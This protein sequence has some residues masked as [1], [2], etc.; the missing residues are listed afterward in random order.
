MST[1][2]PKKLEARISR[3]PETFLRMM[4]YHG[5]VVN[6]EFVTGDIHGN[7]G[8]S[9]GVNLEKALYN[10]LNDAEGRT[11]GKGWIDLIAQ[12]LSADRKAAAKH[13]VETLGWDAAEFQRDRKEPKRKCGDPVMPVPSDAPEIP[14]KIGDPLKRGSKMLLADIYAYFNSDGDLQNYVLRFED[15]A[16]DGGKPS[17]EIRPLSYFETV[18]GWRM[19]GPSKSALTTLFGLELL[20]QQPLSSVILVEGEKAALAARKL[21]PNYVCVT[22]LGGAG[23][24]SKVDWS[25]LSGRDVIYFPDN[26]D[27]GKKTVAPIQR[28]LGLVSAA[29]LRV[30][31]TPKTAPKGWD[32]ADPI[33]EGWDLAL[34]LA[35]A[36]PLDLSPFKQ[37]QE[38]SYLE[39]PENWHFVVETEEF[40]HLPTGLTVKRPA[41]DAL[42]RHLQEAQRGSIGNR[43]LEDFRDNKLVKRVYLPGVPDEIVVV[44]GSMRVLNTWRP[45]KVTAMEGDAA[46]FVNHLR[47]LAGNDEDFDH[48]ADMLAFMIQKQGKKLKSAIILVGKQ[49]TGKSYVG[50]VMR[51]LFGEHNCSVI[52]TNELKSEHNTYMEDKQFVTVEEM[53]AFGHRDVANTLKPLITQSVIPLRKKYANRRNV[54]NTVNFLIFT[55][56]WDALP[57]DQGER[58]FF[59]VGTDADRREIAY[60]DQLWSWTERNYGVVLNWLL[61]RDLSKFNPNARPPMTAAKREMTASARPVVEG[62]IARMIAEYEPPFDRDLVK[63]KRVLQVLSGYMREANLSNVQRGLRANEAK[64]LGQ[65]KALHQG[66]EQKVSL[67]VVRNQE[68]WIQKP[69]AA[70]ARGYFERQSG[71]LKDADQRKLFNRD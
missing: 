4:G 66:R 7:P 9:F 63:V 69:N 11:S 2:D 57:L 24:L 55:N 50:D 67:W 33:P 30:V 6:G 19:R 22:W 31:Q 27:A 10:D 59:V 21:F 20:Q 68:Y 36:E 40:I 26:D 29:S 58:R 46:M 32:L 34:M 53:S 61:K 65:K 14:Y 23:R 43:F 42:Y 47:Y 18:G 1:I 3:D 12:K 25:S 5:E 62:E 13:I 35:K 15:P 45:S 28:A 51:T 48:L 17:K 16:Q 8:K 70:I 54:P 39:L 56:H 38:L 71:A 64:N 44:D 60:Y 37:I 52:E 41:F 49:G